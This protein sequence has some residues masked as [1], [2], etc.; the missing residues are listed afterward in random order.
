MK[1][2]V[3]IIKMVIMS[4]LRVMVTITTAQKMKISIK[5]LLSKCGQIRRKLRIWPHLLKKSLMENFIFCALHDN[6]NCI[7]MISTVKPTTDI[8]L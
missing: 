7:T 3:K 2:K 4:L 8:G 1:E 6:R 5:D